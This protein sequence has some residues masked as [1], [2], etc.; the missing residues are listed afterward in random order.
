MTGVS[1]GIVAVIKKTEDFLREQKIEHGYIIDKDGNILLKKKGTKSSVTLT[2]DERTKLKDNI[3]THNHPGEMQQA[4]SMGDID[5]LV[6]DEL[7]EMRAVT[8]KY[9]YS[10]KLKLPKDVS[11]TEFREEL[12]KKEYAYRA[13]KEYELDNG[14]MTWKEMAPE[15]WHTFW[16]NLNNE[17]DYF[18]YKRNIL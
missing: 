14:I 12:Y 11:V 17:I 4:F 15:Y 1:P 10:A 3:F 16:K 5:T 2:A 13:F 6:I 7:Y 9:N 8:P 18:E